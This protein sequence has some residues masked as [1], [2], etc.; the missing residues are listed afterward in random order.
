[1]TAFGPCGPVLRRDTARLPSRAAHG[2]GPRCRSGGTSCHRL[3]R[4]GCYAA[5]P[6][7]EG[8]PEPGLLYAACQRVLR[9]GG[10]LGV[11]TAGPPTRTVNS[12]TCPATWGQRPGRRAHL[13]PAHRLGA[14]RHPRQPAWSPL[15]CRRRRRAR[16][17]PNPHRPAHLCPARRTAMTS[18][19]PAPA[20]GS[21]PRLGAG[22]FASLNALPA[23]VRPS[24]AQRWGR[25]WPPGVAELTELLCYQPASRP[26]TSMP[27][28]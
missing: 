7:G 15:R 5:Q 28:W 12:P 21:L 22:I 1:V 8:W 26:D 3:P 16:R 13:H 10:I 19:R 11:I 25:R 17:L 4:P 2:G 27:Y 23:A 24:R 6:G 18:R 9:P 14:R 20:P